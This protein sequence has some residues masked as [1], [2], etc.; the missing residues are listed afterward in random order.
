MEPS[1]SNLP[2]SPLKEPP[3]SPSFRPAGEQN[4]TQDLKR[5]QSQGAGRKSFGRRV[6]FAATAHV[7]LYEKGDSDREEAEAEEEDMDFRPPPSRKS[8]PMSK[9]SP[10]PP[11]AAMN[12]PL[13]PSRLHESISF[14]ADAEDVSM[15]STPSAHSG[16]GSLKPGESPSLVHVAAQA[17]L[18]DV[19]RLSTAT[20][21]SEGEASFDVELKDAHSSSFTSYHSAGEEDG[22][23]ELGAHLP[24]RTDDTDM[25]FTS[26]VGGILAKV[27]GPQGQRASAGPTGDGNDT[28]DFTV[29]VGGLIRRLPTV[30]LSDVSQASSVDTMELTE[31]VGQ[32]LSRQNQQ[33]PKQETT[34]KTNASMATAA[35]ENTAMETD[36]DME[37]TTVLPRTIHGGPA[38]RSAAGSTER[39]NSP[40]PFLEGTTPR[41]EP[42]A[43]GITFIGDVGMPDAF[44]LLQSMSPMTVAAAEDPAAA[45]KSAQDRL[46]DALIDTAKCSEEPTPSKAAAYGLQP[47]SLHG[48][49]SV[50]A[51]PRRPVLSS[52][53]ASYS[54]QPSGMPSPSPFLVPSAPPSASVPL[55]DFLNDTGIRFLENISSL[56]RRETTGRPRDSDIVA[57]SRQAF[58]AAAL[59]PQLQF[60]EQVSTC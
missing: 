41:K 42:T 18:P 25:D 5:T 47:A 3:S 59:V 31:C 21:Y 16:R 14:P 8:L 48:S 35:M 60:Y 45:G 2:S 37:M 53:A 54:M 12:S 15:P 27:E 24:P 26:C 11:P 51:T 36:I 43:S 39:L 34:S 10:L 20:N 55:A 1:A 57:P 44:S 13:R 30:R 17:M 4:L 6:S 28:M 9:G 22:T 58:V 38:T 7:R 33:A 46:F 52:L 56:K 19:P 23:M 40:S 49:L 32:I 50:M 29:C